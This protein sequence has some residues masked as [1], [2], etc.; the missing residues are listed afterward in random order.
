MR[1]PVDDAM[2]PGREGTDRTRV[3][4]VWAAMSIARAVGLRPMDS[5]AA[6]VAACA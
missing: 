1:K 2:R 3:Q 5:A 6:V 4:V